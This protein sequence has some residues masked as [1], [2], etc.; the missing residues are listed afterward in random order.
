MMQWLAAYGV[1]V[2]S[3]GIVI[4]VWWIILSPDD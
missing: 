3:G 1:A 4:V 2:F